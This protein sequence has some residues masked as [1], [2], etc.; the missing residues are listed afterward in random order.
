MK[1]K[2]IKDNHALQAY[3]NQRISK[4]LQRLG[5]KGDRMGRD[6]CIPDLPRDTDC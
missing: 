2:G 4:T 6:I 3:F 1:A 5:K